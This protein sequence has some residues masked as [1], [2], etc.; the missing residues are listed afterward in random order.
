MEKNDE[1]T[2][3]QEQFISEM[4]NL[5][6]KSPQDLNERYSTDELVMGI[7]FVDYKLTELKTI[8]DSLL[9]REKEQ[10]VQGDEYENLQELKKNT[11]QALQTYFGIAENF[12]TAL[13]RVYYIYG[14][15]TY[16]PDVSAI[17]YS[18][19]KKEL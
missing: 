10:D 18:N 9:A 16:M 8:Y 3:K 4:V 15:E 12:E 7:Q 2:I 14:Y 1:E 11:V 5:A 13:R 19:M 17:L 6:E